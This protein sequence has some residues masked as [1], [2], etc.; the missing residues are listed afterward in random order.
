MSE[1]R[2]CRHTDTQLI[3]VGV[4][5]EE[6]EEEEEEVFGIFLLERTRHTHA[7]LLLSACVPT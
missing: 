2:T 3:E 1:R 7:R 6:E 4:G 5:Q